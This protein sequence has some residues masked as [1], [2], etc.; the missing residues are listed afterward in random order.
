MEYVLELCCQW[1]MIDCFS[2]MRIVVSRLEISFRDEFGTGINNNFYRKWCDGQK[3]I[4]SKWLYVSNRYTSCEKS[5]PTQVSFA[6]ELYYFLFPMDDCV[7]TLFIS[8]LLLATPQLNFRTF[9]IDRRYHGMNISLYIGWNNLRHRTSFFSSILVTTF[10]YLP[11]LRHD[12]DRC[13]KCPN[14]KLCILHPAIV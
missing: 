11:P 13:Q 3:I 12:L 5:T 2:L 10:Y 9:S 1:S 4:L 14:A 8:Y 6:L 7:M